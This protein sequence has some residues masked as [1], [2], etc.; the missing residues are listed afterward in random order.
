M[1]SSPNEIIIN[2][3]KPRNW[4]KIEEEDNYETLGTEQKITNK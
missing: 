1:Q 4:E 3:T 2:A